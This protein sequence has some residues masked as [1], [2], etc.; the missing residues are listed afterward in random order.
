MHDNNLQYFVIIAPQKK[1]KRFLSLLCDYGAHGTEVVYGRGSVGPSALAAAFGLEANG[2]RVM[3]SCILKT[4]RAKEL[5][6]V[7]YREYQFSKPN[8]GIAFGIS[9]EGLAF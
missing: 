7:L 1:K 9:I 2:N 6:E 5:I 8:T 4:D 3:I